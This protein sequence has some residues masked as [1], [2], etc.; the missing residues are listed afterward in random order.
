MK[1]SNLTDNKRLKKKCPFWIRLL[2]LS[3]MAVTLIGWLR[4]WGAI[5][6]KA[7]LSELGLAPSLQWYLI[8]SGI[9]WGVTLIPGLWTLYL[10]QRWSKPATWLGISFFLFTYWFERLFLWDQTQNARN[11]LF[12]IALCL[13]WLGLNGLVFYLP[14]C[15]VYLNLDGDY[16]MKGN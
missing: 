6:N 16:V 12:M 13:L 5:Q 7:F 10:R 9:L 8:L 4:F 14:N 3:L 1:P 15:R 2:R 11:W